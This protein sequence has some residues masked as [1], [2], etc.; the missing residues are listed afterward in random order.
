MKM[1]NNFSFQID[2]APSCIFLPTHQSPSSL[3]QSL[4]ASSQQNILD[5]ILSSQSNMAAMGRSNVAAMTSSPEVV[6]GSVSG[7]GADWL[8]CCLPSAHLYSNNH[9]QTGAL[10]DLPVTDHQLINAGNGTVSPK[11]VPKK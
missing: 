1:K 7:E 4:P 10:Q 5:R 6:M 3:H 2:M 11:L 9:R 8:V